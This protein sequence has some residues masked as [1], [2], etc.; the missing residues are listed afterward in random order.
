MKNSG[1][2]RNWNCIALSL[3]VF[4]TLSLM[5]L[6]MPGLRDFD[7]EI[8]KITR[9]YLGQFP[10]YIPVFFS[11]YGGVGN[12]WWPQI[13]AGAVLIS[14]QKYLKTFLWVLLFAIFLIPFQSYN[15]IK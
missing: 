6:Y 9:K 1:T 11:N 3:V 14:H 13:T 12:F 2:V 10:N 4:A 7:T 15:T 8:L 5:V